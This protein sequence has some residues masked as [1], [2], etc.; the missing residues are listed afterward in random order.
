MLI[1]SAQPESKVILQRA[2][3][4]ETFYVFKGGFSEYHDNK[5]EQLSA[6]FAKIYKKQH[7]EDPNI[8]L[9]KDRKLSADFKEDIDWT[10]PDGLIYEGRTYKIKKGLVD[11]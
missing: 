3:A 2:H 9:L 4:K 7:M 8:L 6:F 11:Y 10:N 5:P 1:L